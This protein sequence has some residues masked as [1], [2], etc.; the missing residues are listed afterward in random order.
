MAGRNDAANGAVAKQK[1]RRTP[2]TAGESTAMQLFRA[3]KAPVILEVA[4]WISVRG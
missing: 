2:D 4:H 1:F 3:V